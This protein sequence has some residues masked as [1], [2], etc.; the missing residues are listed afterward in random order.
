MKQLILL[1]CLAFF[2][3]S[4]PQPPKKIKLPKAYVYI[5]SGQIEQDGKE[6]AIQGF[7]MQ[8]TEVSN[9][10]YREFLAAL[11]REGRT[12]DLE[13]ARVHPEGWDIPGAY[14]QPFVEH[15]HQHPAFEDY[16]VVNVSREAALLYCEWL[17]KTL[18]AKY[19]DEI[20]KVRLPSETEWMYAARAGHKDAP[21]PHGNYLRNSKGQF[22]Y[23]FRRVGDESIHRNPDTGEIEVKK[24][25]LKRASANVHA[26]PIFVGPTKGK[27][28]SANDFGLYNM[29]GNV[30]EMLAQEGRTKGGCFNST[31]YD[32]RIDAPDEFAGINDASPFIGFRP[33][34]TVLEKKQ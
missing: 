1:C 8:A 16:P 31:G 24:D 17:E 15:Y 6:L 21:Y 22:L 11:E 23:N 32:I 4:T 10:N 34:I 19:P 33:L 18:Q 14:M 29:S 26:G 3:A 7:F 9:L 13:K 27:V 25:A 28:F 2:T 5:P 12:A 20:I 30:A